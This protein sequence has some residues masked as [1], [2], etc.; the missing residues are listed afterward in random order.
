VSV[1][2]FVAQAWSYVPAGRHLDKAL[3][4]EDLPELL[5]DLVQ[6][7]K[8]ASALRRTQSFE[9]VWF[10]VCSLPRSG[11]EH[12]RGQVGDFDGDLLGILWTLFDAVVDDLCGLNQLSLL[13]VGQL[14]RILHSLRLVNLLKRLTSRVLWRSCDR[15]QHI[16]ILLDPLQL[17]GIA[18]TN[19]G[20]LAANN[21]LVTISVVRPFVFFCVYNSYRKLFQGQ[22]AFLLDR[23]PDFVFVTALIAYRLT[24]SSQEYLFGFVCLISQHRSR[25]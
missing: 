21:L 23:I 19:L 20:R 15:Y 11:F 6:R 24:F 2:A 12:L 16:S 14:L 9:V 18:L 8:S 7:V 5:S 13:V 1:K 25:R 3:V 4:E 22:F 10:P 17:E